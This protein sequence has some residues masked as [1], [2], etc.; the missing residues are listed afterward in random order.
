M[1]TSA[2]HLR[3]LHRT[4]VR[5]VSATLLIV[6]SL[7]ATTALLPIARRG[8]LGVA[9]AHA[10]GRV[11]WLF[12]TS[13][14]CIACHNGLTTPSGEDV[15]IGNAWRATMMANSARDPYWQASV[16]REML[17][18]PAANE[19]I[20]DEC[21]VCHMP[22]A[23]YQARAEG[24]KG[25]V[26]AH[27]PIGASTAPVDKLAADGVSCT[28][29]HQIGSQ[30]LGRPESFGGGFVIDETIPPGSRPIYGPFEIDSGRARIMQ[31]SAQYRPMQG[32]HIQSSELCATCHTLY[33]DARDP[34]GRVIARLPEQ[35]PYLEWR[36]SRYAQTQ[37]CQSCHMP[38]VTDSVAISGV[39]GR[40][41][42]HLARH[43]FL[44]GNFFVLRMLNRFRG[45][46]GTEALPHE[47]EAGAQRTLRHLQ[48]STAELTIDRVRRVNGQL[49][50]DVDVRNLAGHK[51][52]TAYPSRRVWVH[53]TVRDDRGSI[54]FESGR[55]DKRGAIE[56]N[57]G[58]ADARRYEPHYR[59]I[60]DSSQV[61]IYES[62]MVDEK[63]AVTTSLLSGVRFMK[64]NRV[65]P[66]GFEKSGA[67]AD[68]AV[69]G[70]AS[71][72]PD[73]V[74]GG[75]RIRYAIDVSRAAGSLRIEAELAYQ[76]IAFRWA[77]NLSGH[78]AREIS[79]FVGY[80]EQMANG[81]STILAHD[82][83]TLR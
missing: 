2:K 1:S 26:F 36:R 76:P 77:H 6:L 12:E 55:L 35:V 71:D 23:R 50:A 52:P 65:L 19:E 81:S 13:D 75:D 21:A 9:V 37:S 73:F 5:R 38:L 61:Q 80:Y 4:I 31:S 54:L 82:A 79:R 48:T 51:L 59:E 8:G 28:T 24:R 20:E 83:K 72:D 58:D 33:T 68:I 17:E 46:L 60:T 49:L 34:S 63:G 39:W 22:M 56:G 64:D 30:G 18:H 32:A 16:R 42:E 44:G 45:E 57:D 70:A 78:D 29:C 69:R 67:E 62:V 40:P 41:R 15:S 11:P 3:E 66:E 7:G 53:F 14:G 25:T 27:L 74:G 43:E 10:A 47:M